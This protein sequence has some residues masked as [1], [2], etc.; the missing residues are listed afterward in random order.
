MLQFDKGGGV[1][2]V[3]EEGGTRKIRGTVCGS[4]SHGFSQ[5]SLA[6]TGVKTPMHENV[7]YGGASSGP[8]NGVPLVLIGAKAVAKKAMNKLRKKLVL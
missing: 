7:L 4:V 1:F 2:K 3:G 6:R 8:G 5:L